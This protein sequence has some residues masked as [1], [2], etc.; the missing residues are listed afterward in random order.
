MLVDTAVVGHLGAAEL[1]GLAIGAL[2]LTDAAWL[3]NFL[4]YGTTA[5]SAR[6]YGAG[7]RDDAVRY[8]RAGDLARRA[9]SASSWSRCCS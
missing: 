4:I 3:C 5:M 2:L 1:G 8:G 6:L 9:A 7:R